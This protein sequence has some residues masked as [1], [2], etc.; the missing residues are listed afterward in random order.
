MSE[1]W[2]YR[3]F[4]EEFGPMPLDEL[5]QLA[6]FGTLAAA[7]KVRSSQSSEWVIAA[8]VAELGLAM[9][10]TAEIACQLSRTETAL[11]ALK[12][13]SD[14]W[15]CQLGGQELGPMTFDELAEHVR[16]E[17][18]TADDDVKLGTDGKWRRVGSI[19]R[20]VAVIPYQ[21]LERN[22]VPT[23]PKPKPPVFEEP[24][25][26]DDD[27]SE[28]VTD[29]E[30]PAE[31]TEN[32]SVVQA[33]YHAAYEGAKAKIVQT[34]LAQAEQAFKQSEAQANSQIAWATG[35]NV[36]RQ[37]WGW[38]SGAEFGPVDFQQVLGLARNG[39]LK[40][41]DLVRNGQFGQFGPSGNIP[42]LFNAVAMLARA[43]EDLQLAK[44][45]TTAAA[46]VLTPPEVAL[47]KPPLVETPPPVKK[48]KSPSRGTARRAASPSIDDLVE[49]D[50][51]NSKQAPPSVARPVSLPTPIETARSSPVPAPHEPPESDPV[52]PPPPAPRAWSSAGP[53]PQAVPLSQ[54][55]AAISRPI[56]PPKPKKVERRSGPSWISEKLEQLKEPKVIGVLAAIGVVALVL[57]WGVLPKS[58]AADIKHYRDLKQMLADIRAAR[59]NPSAML[60]LKPKAT[61]LGKEVTEAVKK[62]AGRDDPAKQ[63]LLWAA[64]DEIPRVLDG[65]PE[66]QAVAEKNMEARLQEAAYELGLEKRPAVTAPQ[67]SLPDD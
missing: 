66:G 46:S 15:Y 22:I 50:F 19:G 4:D 43:T 51:L 31:P 5:K 28:L 9:T 59:Q 12:H 53:G 45:R 47:P 6:D 64:R 7:D 48:S 11:P 29:E 44:T 16:N 55:S 35:P 57:F 36:D 33:A 13:N 17:Q 49:E 27:L 34:M 67:G 38:A 25:T 8:S 32:A 65:T 1:L 40:P 20:L 62:Q 63:C 30:A 54:S 2:Y 18:L 3:M 52:E 26:Q 60:E 14:D 58:R 56:V 24:S 23:P 37:W 21:A 42:G 41:N 10:E 61:K 39:Q